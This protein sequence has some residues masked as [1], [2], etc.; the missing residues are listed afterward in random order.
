MA[1]SRTWPGST[2]KRP[3]RFAALTHLPPPRHNIP[4]KSIA[5]FCLIGAAALAAD[6]RLGIIGTDT[7]HVIVFT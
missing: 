5:L 3:E 6:I 7:S 4:M 1:R 2:P